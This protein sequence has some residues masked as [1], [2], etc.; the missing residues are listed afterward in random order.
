M[1]RREEIE[2]LLRQKPWTPNEL[3]EHLG[4][5]LNEIV[6]DLEHVRRNVQKPHVFKHQ[7]PKC[8]DCGFIFEEIAKMKKPSKC[9]KCHSDSIDD[10]RYF[11]RQE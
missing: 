6:E 3:A 7:P 8:H 11:V 5:P 10:G 2:E 4:A 1:T 9:P